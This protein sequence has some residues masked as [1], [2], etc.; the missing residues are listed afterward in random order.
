MIRSHIYFMYQSWTTFDL[1]KFDFSIFIFL[2]K[3]LLYYLFNGHCIYCFISAYNRINL[4]KN[5]S[6][7]HATPQIYAIYFLRSIRLT[8][9]IYLYI[10]IVFEYVRIKYIVQ[11]RDVSI[12]KSIIGY[13]TT[14]ELYIVAL[15]SEG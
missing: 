10:Y 2:I 7:I 3:H 11:N 6:N 15:K 8:V 1:L 4:W 13:F 14:H 5:S 12:R 9:Y